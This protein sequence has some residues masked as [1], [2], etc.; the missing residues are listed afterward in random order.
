MSILV[1]VAQ[2]GRLFHW[3]AGLQQGSHW[4]NG[5]SWLSWSLTVATMTW[6]TAMENLRQKL[7]RICSTCR[8]TSRSSP[9]WRLITGFVTR[10]TRRVP[11][12]E[13]ELPTLPEHPSPL[14]VISE[15]PV[16]RSLVLC[17]CFVNRCLFFCTFSFCHCVMIIPLVSANSS[18]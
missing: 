15:I 5:S 11:L 2:C 18:Y 14:P 4:T 3:S 12:E 1:L 17:V 10:L 7:P 13:K 9:H 16:T 6:L 8:N